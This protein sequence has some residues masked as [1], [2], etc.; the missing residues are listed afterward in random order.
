MI[1]TSITLATTFKR[2]R[3]VWVGI[4]PLPLKKNTPLSCLYWWGRALVYCWTD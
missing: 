3:E 1:C 4:D 2:W